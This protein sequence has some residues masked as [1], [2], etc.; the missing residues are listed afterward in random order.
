MRKK[1]P[2]KLSSRKVSKKRFQY[3]AN[4]LSYVESG[5]LLFAAA[6]PGLATQ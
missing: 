4:L 3:L 2:L 6:N 1:H 5:A